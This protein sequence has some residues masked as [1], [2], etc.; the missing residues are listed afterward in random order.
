MDTLHLLEASRVPY[1]TQ[2]IITPTVIQKKAKRQNLTNIL[3]IWYEISF[4]VL[5]MISMKY[6]LACR[7][8]TDPKWVPHWFHI[9]QCSIVQESCICLMNDR[10]L[11]S[12]AKRW[13]Y[14]IVYRW[15]RT[16]YP[17][18]GMYECIGIVVYKLV[19]SNFQTNFQNNC[20]SYDLW[21]RF[22]S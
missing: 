4:I 18:N 1:H 19:G 22:S 12:I 9:Y 6:F 7:V 21:I 2:R 10:Y 16:N 3:Q 11:V 17:T 8:L 13:Y 20:N 14:S 5:N 15:Y